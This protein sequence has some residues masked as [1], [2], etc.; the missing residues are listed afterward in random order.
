MAVPWSVWVRKTVLRRLGRPETLGDR[1]S[2]PEHLLRESWDRNPPD[3][4]QKPPPTDWPNSAVEFG[5]TVEVGSQKSTVFLNA[6][7]HPS[8]GGGFGHLICSTFTL[9]AGTR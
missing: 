5:F 4:G 9:D 7:K 8:I 1:L 6:Q 2:F 3:S